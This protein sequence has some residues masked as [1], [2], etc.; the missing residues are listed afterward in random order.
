MSLLYISLGFTVTMLLVTVLWA[1]A[2]ALFKGQKG[3][4]CPEFFLFSPSDFW[5]LCP[6]FPSRFCPNLG[7]QLPID[8]PIRMHLNCPVSE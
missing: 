5:L 8:C 4:M 2:D 6:K 1:Y 7:W 3:L